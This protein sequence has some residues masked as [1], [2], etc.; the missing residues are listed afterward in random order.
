MTPVEKYNPHERAPN[1]VRELYNE[2]RHF[3]P[4]QLCEHPRILDLQ[5]L[6]LNRLPD[7]LFL[8][9]R[10]P[11]SV[12]DLA[13]DDF[14][15]NSSWRTGLEGSVEGANVYGIKQVPGTYYSVAKDALKF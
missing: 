10:I 2:C 15:G 7:G 14:I 3:D 1:A 8:E 13:F 9:G 12:L 11:Q 5:G 4:S 6:D